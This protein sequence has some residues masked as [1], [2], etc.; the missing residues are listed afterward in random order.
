MF[1]LNS[2]QKTVE[3]KVYKVIRNGNIKFIPSRFGDC[4]MHLHLNGKNFQGANPG[5]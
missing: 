5:G 4:K 2:F 3:N 1:K